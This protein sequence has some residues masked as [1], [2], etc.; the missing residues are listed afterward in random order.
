MKK[1]LQLMIAAIA[2]AGLAH[3]AAAAPAAQEGH[4]GAQFVWVTAI[5]GRDSNGS[6][7]VLYS[8]LQGSLLP[9]DKLAQAKQLIKP[10]ADAP[11]GN[12]GE[13]TLQLANK[14]LTVSRNGIEQGPLPKH[15]STEVRLD[16][17]LQIREEKQA[18]ATNS[19]AHQ[20]ADHHT[21]ALLQ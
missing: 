17:Q 15:L 8:N 1:Q 14:L 12:Y 18:L 4:N 19:P 9:V 2:M 16:G 21:L 3:S 10:D 7:R 13:L 11:H 6:E 20:Q 5:K